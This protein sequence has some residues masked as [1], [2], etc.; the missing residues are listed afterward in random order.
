MPEPLARL[1]AA[2]SSQPARKW[3]EAEMCAVAR[4]SA[5]HLRRM[6]QNQLGT[7]PRGWRRNERI[8]LAQKLLL[9]SDA[10]IGTV[11]ERCGFSD[12]YHFSRDFKRAVGTSPRDW[13]RSESG[14]PAGVLYEKS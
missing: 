12:V 11:A 14:D 3:S 7:T 2:M 6:F 4:V 9:A 13:R 5:S 10:R 1:M 8:M